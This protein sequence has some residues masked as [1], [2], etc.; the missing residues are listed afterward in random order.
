MKAVATKERFNLALGIPH[1]H[2]RG[3]ERT[4]LEDLFRV[5]SEFVFPFLGASGAHDHVNFGGGEE[6]GGC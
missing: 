4:L 3:T 2:P 5:A 1:H 6:G